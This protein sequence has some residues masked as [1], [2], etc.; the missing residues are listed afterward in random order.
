MLARYAEG[1]TLLKTDLRWL[2][3]SVLFSCAT[4][5][6]TT[7]PG[8]IHCDLA[9]RN[10]LVDSGGGMVNSGLV[11]KIADFGLSRSRD[12]KLKTAFHGPHGIFAV[13]WAAPEVIQHLRFTA[14]SDCWSYAIV[15][16]EIFED[17]TCCTFSPGR[18]LRALHFYA[19][20]QLC[21]GA[22][23]AVSEP[24]CTESGLF[25][26]CRALL[27]PSLAKLAGLLLSTFSKRK[28]CS[29]VDWF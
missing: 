15:L 21:C 17:G 10:V 7:Q 12:A 5:S 26:T 14:A 11:C 29:V 23:I 6:T 8:F 19:A 22:G 27:S 3:C 2:L 25:T 18:R 1:I 24:P 20:A 4:C 16:L 9:A 13:R 28:C